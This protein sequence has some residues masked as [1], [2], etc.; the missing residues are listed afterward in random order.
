MLS[1]KVGCV[2]SHLYWSGISKASQETA[3]SDSCQ[4]GS[5]LYLEA[6]RIIG[7]E[8]KVVLFLKTRVKIICLSLLVK[9]VHPPRRAQPWV[10]ACARAGEH[11]HVCSCMWRSK[12]NVGLSPS[13]SYFSRQSLPLNL[14]LFC[15]TGWVGQQALGICLPP[16]PR[17]YV[18]G[19]VR[20]EL[21]S[22]SLHS[23]HFSDEPSPN[24]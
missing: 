7:M 22:S 18:G 10:C 16:M 13:P 1:S 9:E 2:H 11:V 19:R 8:I 14:E 5:A 23:R 12:V 20:H 4:Q 3:V 6:P 24:P 15:S 21:R 17:F